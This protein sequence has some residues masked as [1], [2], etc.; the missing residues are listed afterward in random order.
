[1]ELK[2]KNCIVVLRK[3]YFIA[4]KHSFLII[5]EKTDRFYLS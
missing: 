1:M 5:W 2:E 4:I 3:G